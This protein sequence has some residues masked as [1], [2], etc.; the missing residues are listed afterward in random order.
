MIFRYLFL[1]ITATVTTTYLQLHVSFC[2]T[3]NEA[4]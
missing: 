4:L 3:T 1:E 2:E